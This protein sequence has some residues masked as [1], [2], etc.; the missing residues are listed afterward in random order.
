MAGMFV[1]I[2]P[3]LRDSLGDYAVNAQD[4]LI[5]HSPYSYAGLGIVVIA[6]MVLLSRTATTS[7]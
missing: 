4:Y 7:R 3:K 1:A 6:L 5:T 2:S